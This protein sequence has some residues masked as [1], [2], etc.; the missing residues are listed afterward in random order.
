[1]TAPMDPILLTAEA[2]RPLLTP[3]TSFAPLVRLVR[4]MQ[5]GDRIIVRQN[6]ELA[7]LLGAY[8]AQFQEQVVHDCSY[9]LRQLLFWVE[10]LDASRAVLRDAQVRRGLEHL[11]VA[12][13]Y[14]IENDP[15][16]TSR[17]ELGCWNA[18]HQFYCDAL[19]LADRLHKFEIN[20]P[21]RRIRPERIKRWER[22]GASSCSLSQSMMNCV[23]QAIPNVLQLEPLRG[24]WPLLRYHFTCSIFPWKQWRSIPG[25][26]DN[27]L[28]MIDSGAF[29][30]LGGA[31]GQVIERVGV[32]EFFDD[33]YFFDP[34]TGRTQHNVVFALSHRQSFLDLFLQSELLRDK[35]CASW[36]DIQH[37]PSSAATDP[38]IV[39]VKPGVT[40]RLDQALA[41]SA[42]LAIDQRYPISNYVDGGTPY[43][44]YGQQM[45]VKPGIRLLVDC[46]VEKSAGTGRK[47][48]VAPVSY[49]DTM[50]FIRGQDSGV[51]LIVHRP[52]CADDTE[53]AP[54]RG[55][56]RAINRGD[57]LTLFL[58]ATFLAHTGQTRHG[59]S[60]PDVVQAVRMLHRELIG[61]RSLRAR[62]RRRFHAS[63]LDACRN[64][65]A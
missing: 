19:A 31:R 45:R 64:N 12:R 51:R 2:S 40:R 7:R 55:D 26:R 50:S 35:V 3:A 38:L 63:I 34:G 29:A 33:P 27:A 5:T 58:E 28:H 41:R 44:P 30:S 52:I 54:K 15:W 65:S 23:E 14:L 60:T 17:S 20:Y 11:Q 22:D 49:D 18:F 6:D 42:E 39:T 36:S 4:E 62:L 13:R 24:L 25:Y 43:V 10:Q 37:F 1:M 57:P 32:A 16:S 53:P 9:N 56:R 48:Y 47:T 8:R 21:I 46:L 61:D 59:W